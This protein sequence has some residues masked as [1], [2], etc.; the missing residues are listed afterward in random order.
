[1]LDRRHEL[2]GADR[3]GH[4]LDVVGEGT[5]LD[6]G[7]RQGAKEV[8]RRADPH[9]GLERCEKLDALRA[10]KQLDRERPFDVLQHL[11]AL[12]R[13]RVPHRHVIL[14][15]RARR[16][17]VDPGRVAEHLVLAD[18]RSRD[19]LRDHEARVQAAVVGQ[20]RGQPVRERRVR[21]PLDAPLGDGREL[22]ERH[23]RAVE[24][25]CQR[26]PVEVPVRHELAL[27]DEDQG[28]VRRRVQLDPDGRLGVGEQVAARA[29]TC[30]AQRSE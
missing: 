9:P 11:E 4:G 29:V 10:G 5:V 23:R 18:E 24:G 27:L 7:G 30:G 1:M 16:D 14:L 21:E 15:P 26:L 3:G 8:V 28:I 25:E 2:A 20:E 12:E 19:V 22:G 13:G 6:H 17:G